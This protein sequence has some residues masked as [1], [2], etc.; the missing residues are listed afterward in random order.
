M[1]LRSRSSSAQAGSRFSAVPLRHAH[2]SPDLALAQCTQQRSLALTTCM[3]DYGVHH[4][5]HQ[6]AAGSPPSERRGAESGIGVPERSFTNPRG[7]Y[8]PAQFGTD[9]QPT[10][11]VREIFPRVAL[12]RPSLLLL[13]ERRCYHEKL[14]AL[15]QVI[16]VAMRALLIMEKSGRAKRIPSTIP[17][18][19]L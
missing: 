18:P 6:S 14:W 8:L 10:R 2:S 1:D 16:L 19:V 5:G 4:P 15:S 12:M 9:I 3:D 17:G 7:V 11:S 13:Y